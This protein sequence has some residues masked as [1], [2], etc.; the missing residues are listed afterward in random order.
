M[1][2]YQAITGNGNRRN[3]SATTHAA[4]VK[5]VCRLLQ[6]PELPPYVSVVRTVG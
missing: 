3:L 1:S 6:K 4:A 2:K 5:E